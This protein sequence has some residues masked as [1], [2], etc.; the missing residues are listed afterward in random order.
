MK[1]NKIN[2]TKKRKGGAIQVCP[3]CKRKGKKTVYS[4]G[5]TSFYHEGHWI[6]FGPWGKTESITDHC[7]IKGS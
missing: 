7:F 6:Y 3:E 4:N 2:W 5:D 1:D